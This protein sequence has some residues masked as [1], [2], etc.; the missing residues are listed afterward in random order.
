MGQTTEE[1][2]AQISEQRDT[3]GRDLEAI[4]DR[5][6]PSRMAQRRK[7]AVRERWNSTKDR[8]MGTTADT[9]GRASN[10]A[11]GVGEAVGSL[12]SRAANVAEGNPL[13]VGLVAFGAGLVVATLLPETG[14]EQR[15]AEKMQPAA[16]ETA[17]QLGAATQDTVEQLKPKAQDAVERVKASAQDSVENVKQ[18]ASDATSQSATEAKNAAASVRSTQD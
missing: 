16:E 7:E 4:G 10:A 8:V 6:S 17:R 15:V 18:D 3:L 12:P 9:S 11:S 5:V 14:V 2:K 13:A 1:L